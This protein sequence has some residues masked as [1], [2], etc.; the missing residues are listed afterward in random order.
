MR[1]ARITTTITAVLL[2]LFTYACS[3]GQQST[4]P[5]PAETT[6]S[7]NA[8]ASD[9]AAMVNGEAIPMSELQTAV[10]NVVMQ[11]GMD[12]GQLDAFMGQFGPRILDQ[13]ID[14]EL[15]FQA[16]KEGSHK[17]AEE[18]IDAAFAELSARYEDP[19]EFQTEMTA[20]GFTEAGLK[21]SIS[22]QMTIQKFIQ[23]TVVPKAVLPEATIREAYDQN[24]QKFSGE[25]EVQASHILINS[26]EGDPQEKKD[27]A[28]KR[29][30]EVAAKA[31]ADGA[32]FAELAR[33]YSE[34]PSAPSGGDLGSFGKGRMVPA[35][36]AAAFSMKVNEVS[37]PVLTQFGY[38]VIKVTGRNEV[39]TVSFD[40]VKEDLEKDLKNRMINELIGEKLSQLR[41][42]AKV[43]VLFT[44]PPQAAAPG[45]APHGQSMR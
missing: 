23:E 44:P 1:T 9:A 8:A 36:E 45:G 18:E 14:G 2:I 24:P 40:E 21:A 33:T 12:P 25:E 43:E 27:E 11:N 35:F 38:H 34:G 16:A 42:N 3:Q 30:R 37:D 19:A 13:L 26:A 5:A 15:L 22:K 32:D 4:E 41:E 10:R 29:A 6:A 39:K 28:L 17:A 7:S 31:K 20:R